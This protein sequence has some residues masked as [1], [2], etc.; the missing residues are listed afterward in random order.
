MTKEEV[1]K[2]KAKETFYDFNFEKDLSIDKFKLDE[3]C[4]SHSTLYFRYAEA[5]IVAKSEVSKADDNLKLITAEQNI[6]IRKAYNDNGVKFTESVIAS[7]LEKDKKVLNAKEQLR[8]AQEIYAKLQ[9]A[10][11]AMDMRKSE[12]DNL[13]RLYC[14]GYFSVPTV[15]NE[16]KKTVNEQTSKS[17]RKKLN[18]E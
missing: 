15:T 3:E 17:L 9:V 5:S 4:L 12:L 16:V 6:A 13:V 10:V 1:K 18:K 11:S 7:E 14:S 2:Q 8:T